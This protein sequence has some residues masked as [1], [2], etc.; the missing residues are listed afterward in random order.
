MHALG[1]QHEHLRSDRDDYLKVDWSNI[2]PQFYDYFA[3][4]NP[5]QYTPYGRFPSAS[6]H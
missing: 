2:N 1:A 3:I 6:T 4:V 5:A